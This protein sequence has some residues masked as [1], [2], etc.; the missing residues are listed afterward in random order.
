MERIRW[1]SL[2]IYE[3]CISLIGDLVLWMSVCHLGRFGRSL[4]PNLVAFRFAARSTSEHRFHAWQRL[5]LPMFSVYQ[6]LDGMHPLKDKTN[7]DN[8]LV[9]IQFHRNCSTVLE[10]ILHFF[11]SAFHH[12]FYLGV[13]YQRELSTVSTTVHSNRMSAEHLLT[14]SDQ[15]DRQNELHLVTEWGDD[16]AMV[17]W[18]LQPSGESH[19]LV[20]LI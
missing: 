10:R 14:S 19:L 2:R 6:P 9:Y 4:K 13:W 20:P 18:T 11:D 12:R 16:L 7:S 15:P 3:E 17:W 1:E 5:K 8:Q